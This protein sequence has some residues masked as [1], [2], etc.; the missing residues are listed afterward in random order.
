ML[1]GFLGHFIGGFLMTAIPRFSNTEKASQ[2][3]VLI[4]LGALILGLFL[5]AGDNIWSIPITGS[6]QSFCLILF[7]T[8]RM[9][10]KKKAKLNP[11]PSFVFI[12]MALGLWFGSSVFS[13]IKGEDFSYIFFEGTVTA[14]ILAI[15]TRIIP[16]ICGHTQILPTPNEKLISPVLLL[17]AF[18]Y[19]STFLI[20]IP[21]EV[22]NFVRFTIISFVIFKYWF[23][24]K[25]P[26]NKAV[27]SYCL[28]LSGWFI[29][30]SHLMNV[31]APFDGGI[32]ITHQLFISGY[33]L[34]TLLISVRV[35]QSH[36]PKDES[37]EKRKILYTISGLLFFGAMTRV[38]S[39]FL[40]QVYSSHLSYSSIVSL[41]AIMLW[42]V[43]YLPLIFIPEK[44]ELNL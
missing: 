32:H 30:I 9:I 12:P 4:Y 31:Y 22:A 26:P 10:I 6:L 7:I 27:L 13:L 3:E 20:K 33:T 21:L 44:K 19:L 42:T 43:V 34:L 17:A 36:G 2:Y 5:I 1:N 24:T 37:Y 41:I 15:G 38:S 14:L 39:Y 23:I 28:K 29:V 8:K 25:R 35:L 40:P 18:S 11:P 16:G